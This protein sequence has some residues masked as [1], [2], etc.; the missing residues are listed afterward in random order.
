MN[1]ENITVILLAISIVLFGV[2]VSAAI[3]FADAA[4]ERGAEVDVLSAALSAAKA[5][6]AECAKKLKELESFVAINPTIQLA[7][8]WRLD[9]VEDN[10]RN[11]RR[12]NDLHE[13]LSALQA[14]YQ[15]LQSKAAL[16]E[17]LNLSAA[18]DLVVV[19]GELNKA[20]A[21]TPELD[22]GAD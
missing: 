20:S 3:M 6:P 17:E 19:Y 5:H 1:P 7:W 11:L 4:R 14:T 9:A 8:A 2:A 10:M 21:A 12:I 13:E 22:R 16:L 15:Q 18:Q